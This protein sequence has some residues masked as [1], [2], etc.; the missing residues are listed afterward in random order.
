M[1]PVDPDPRTAAAAQDFVSAA[2][3]F[4][5]TLTAVP[6]EGWDRPGLGEWSIRSLA[7]HT[8][9]ALVT[10]S[11][12]V[13]TPAATRDHDSAVAYYQ[14]VL[15]VPS[16]AELNAAV[17]R[18]GVE[19]GRQLGDDPVGTVEG[20]LR[21][22]RAAIETTDPDAVVTTRAGGMRLRDYLPTRSFELVVH[23]LDLTAALEDL[24]VRTGP[25]PAPAV[26]STLRLAADI[27]AATGQGVPLLRALTGRGSL[28][29]GFSVVP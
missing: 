20:W 28:P 10:V 4:V 17:A 23:T 8:A 3:A 24:G 22:A 14:A 12:A 27:A 9:R 7:G 19:A 6:Q 26:Q 2:T 21:N 15:S 29:A 16:V 13:A 5:Q 18:R 1:T 11:D 25:L